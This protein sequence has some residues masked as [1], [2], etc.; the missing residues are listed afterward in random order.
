MKKTL[1]IMAV[2]FV[3]AAMA[4]GIAACSGGTNNNTP[5]SNGTN[6]NTTPENSGNQSNTQTNNTPNDSTPDD[7]TP[8]D[9]TSEDTNPTD[10]GNDAESGDAVTVAYSFKGGD[11]GPMGGSGAIVTLSSDGTA[12]G[13]T[14]YIGAD[15]VTVYATYSSQ[16][17]TWTEADGVITLTMDTQLTNSPV[18]YTG[19]EA[20]GVAVNF[21]EASFALEYKAD[22]NAFVGGELSETGGSGVVL[23]LSEDGTCKATHGYIG[24]DG[25]TLYAEYSSMEGSYTVEDGTYTFTLNEQVASPIEESYT[26]TVADGFTFAPGGGDGYAVTLVTE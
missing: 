5:A 9:T 18:E 16:T 17:G 24:G 8:A 20:D 6:S 21:G 4:L 1:K 19:T 22:N 10:G 23:Q 14:G 2:L 7:S 3:I 25:I 11:L 15:G 26:F 12:S 13:F